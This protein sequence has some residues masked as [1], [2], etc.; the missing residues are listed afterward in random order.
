MLRFYYIYGN[1]WRYM[2][3]ANINLDDEVF[4][5][6]ARA[7]FRK[8]EERYEASLEFFESDEFDFYFEKI[9]KYVDEHYCLRDEDVMYGDDYPITFEQLDKVCISIQNSMNVISEDESEWHYRGYRIE[10]VCGQGC[11]RTIIKL[12]VHE[13]ITSSDGCDECLD[14]GVSNF[15]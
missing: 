8:Y 2:K 14:C 11:Y 3:F 7:F 4:H 15:K 12:C 9:T 6:R 13:N 5:E 10:L 1:Y